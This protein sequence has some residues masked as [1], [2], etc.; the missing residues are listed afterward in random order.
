MIFGAVFTP[1]GLRKFVESWLGFLG[2]LSKSPLR[3]IMIFIT[4][5]I[6]GAALRTVLN[7]TFKQPKER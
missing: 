4:E 3:D 7:E 2:R 6:A 1:M 5:S